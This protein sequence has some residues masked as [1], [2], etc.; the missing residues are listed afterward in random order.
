MQSSEQNS[1]KINFEDM[2]YALSTQPSLIISTLD[3]MRQTCLIE[4]TI[5]V[6]EE[7]EMINKYLKR[8]TLIRIIVYG[9]NAAD[10]SIVKKYNQLV[11]LGFSN[12][13]VYPGG[14]FEWLLLQDI[15]GAE[16][17]PTTSPETDILKY[18]GRRFLGVLML[19]N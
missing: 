15:Y 4:G 16:L 6:T 17:F 8:D 2:Q 5:I 1:R 11:G 19:D 10:D 3:T 18:K 14:L 13:Y 9:E 7:T 12:V